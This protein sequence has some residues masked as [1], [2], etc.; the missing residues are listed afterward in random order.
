[1]GRGR[2]SNF[3]ASRCYSQNAHLRDGA[4]PRAVNLPV[5]TIL[6]ID[7]IE[8]LTVTFSKLFAKKKMKKEREKC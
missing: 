3:S 7:L 1:M 5:F 8:Y 4:L 6:K 2:G